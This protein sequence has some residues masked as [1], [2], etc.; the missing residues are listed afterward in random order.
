MRETASVRR[1]APRNVASIL[2]SARELGIRDAQGNTTTLA[3][4]LHLLE[5]A[6]LLAGLPRYIGS[7]VRRGS[8]PKLNVLNTAFMT[9]YSGYTRDAAMADRTF[10]GRLVESAV[11][12]HL[13]NTATSDM[14]LYYWRDG[15]HEVDFVLRHGR[16]LVAIEAKS[17]RS[18]PTSLRGLARFTERFR[19]QHSLIVGEGGI[20]LQEFFAS[21]AARWLEEA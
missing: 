16:K 3:D 18:K 14:R 13:F 2:D 4:Y 5:M 19:P 21:P 17:G 15:L 9:A 12:A 1:Q 7:P 10:W 8:S 20:S 11:G 6:G